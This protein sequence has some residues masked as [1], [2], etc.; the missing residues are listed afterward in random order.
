MS[1]NSMVPLPPTIN[2]MQKPSLQIKKFS[3][4][5]TMW[6][7]GGSILLGMIVII[8]VFKLVFSTNNK[9]DQNLEKSSKQTVPPTNELKEIVYTLTNTPTEEVL[10]TNS[11]QIS[12]FKVT[13]PTPT[14][15]VDNSLGRSGC[16]GNSEILKTL[17]PHKC[18]GE[19]FSCNNNKP[20]LETYKTC[21]ELYKSMDLKNEEEWNASCKDII[22]PAALNNTITC[23]NEDNNIKIT[24]TSN[25]T[26]EIPKDLITDKDRCLGSNQIVCI[27][28]IWTTNKVSN[29]SDVY[30]EYGG[31][32]EWQKQCNDKLG[33]TNY[34]NLLTCT[35][36]S[37]GVNIVSKQLCL[38]ENTDTITETDRCNGLLQFKCTDKGW[39]KDMANSCSDIYKSLNLNSEYEWNKKCN[40]I[41]GDQSKINI[42]RCKEEQ[43]SDS[44]KK[45][46][47]STISC[48][49]TI[50][51][52]MLV[53]DIDRCNGLV[54]QCTSNGWIK[55]QLTNCAD[56]YQEIGGVGSMDWNI[57]CK[58]IMGDTNYINNIKCMDVS[59]SKP[60]IEVTKLCPKKEPN[61]AI[62]FSERCEGMGWVCNE[63]KKEWV[64]DYK[65]NT[66][67]KMYGYITGVEKGTEGMWKA[68]CKDHIG[69][70]NT[71]NTNMRC[72]ES[73]DKKSVKGVVDVG[74]T[75]TPPKD[76]CKDASGNEGKCPVGMIC[77]CDSSNNWGCVAQKPSE[78]CKVPQVVQCKDKRAAKCIVC[79]DKMKELVCTDSTPSAECLTSIYGIKK[80]SAKESTTGVNTPYYVTSK[81]IPVY[82]LIDNNLCRKN[83]QPHDMLTP[84]NGDYI[85]H[86][87]FNNMK[88]WIN[89]DKDGN[90][91]YYK[92]NKSLPKIRNKKGVMCLDI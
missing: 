48:S 89:K 50:P 52:N 76:A 81:N 84:I 14:T 87:T 80:E 32:E 27:N 40:T 49:K 88:G 33:D 54:S 15:K 38:K 6:Y 66:C 7:I 39:E 53:T 90:T 13:I 72:V 18:Y 85:G 37:G 24:L 55:T 74:C 36:V 4:D 83:Q 73:K 61:E 29:C 46:I 86:P 57:K 78:E 60:K 42:M 20:V 16:N 63:E 19:K 11:Q 82:P 58:D 35:D 31:M 41:V 45:P 67:D 1:S 28:N 3:N 69:P 43:R 9:I 5:H 34:N 22:G 79:S 21:D 92:P 71:I 70:S 77:M 2:R 65:F 12:Q 17:K 91:S 51:D 25:C 68:Q 59:G 75:K 64:K 10:E 30:K 47:I 62:S 56:V 23:K 26:K 44:T 8:V